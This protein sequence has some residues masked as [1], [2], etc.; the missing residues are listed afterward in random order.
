MT[1][2]NGLFPPKKSEDGLLYKS[3]EN[4]YFKM[5]LFWPLVCKNSKHS[6]QNFVLLFK[7]RLNDLIST[8]KT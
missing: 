4:I 8:Y 1:F 6:V 5:Q 7:A 2:L 3:Y